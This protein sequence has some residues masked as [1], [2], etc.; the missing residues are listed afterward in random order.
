VTLTASLTEG[1]T[2]ILFSHWTVNGEKQ[3]ST[4]STLSLP[5]DAHKTV[6]AIFIPRPITVN[7]TEDTAGSVETITLRYALNSVKD[8]G[9]IIL[10]ER[11]VITLTNAL[12][13]ITKSIT[14]EGNGSTLTSSN[15]RLLSISCKTGP[16]KVSRLHFNGNSS[17]SFT[18]SGRAISADSPL[19]L[20]SG[21]FS[22]NSSGNSSD[23]HGG[24]IYQ[25]DT[26]KLGGLTVLGC[27]FYNN[28]TTSTTGYGGAIYSSASATLTGNLFLQNNTSGSG[29]VWG[30]SISSGGYN[31]S[32][33][34]DGLFA[35]DTENS[36]YAGATG[37]LF[38]VTDIT[39][40]TNE[41]P[42]TAPSCSAA[43][44]L[45]TL[46]ALPEGF[47]TTYFDGTERTLPATAGAMKAAAQ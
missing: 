6:Q 35:L 23:T 34:T 22:D 16:V 44:N 7:S 45:N 31:V 2:D 5:M 11:S 4:N 17:D 43:S 47:P 27:T 8:G 26:Y 46:T 33:G 3:E 12:P 38:S 13:Q 41:D 15:I 20:E 30:K 1:L 10:P 14:I 32:D 37:D 36:G 25:R 42:T 39:F 19:T 24:A 28:K 40:A 21:I 29:N 18:G 9:S